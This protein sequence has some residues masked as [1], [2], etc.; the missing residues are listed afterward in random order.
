MG[1]VSKNGHGSCNHVN[2]ATFLEKYGSL[3]KQDTTEPA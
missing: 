3:I 1:E 2:E